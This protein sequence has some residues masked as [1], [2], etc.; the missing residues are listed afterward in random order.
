MTRVTGIYAA[1]D[2]PGPLDKADS[3]TLKLLFDSVFPEYFRKAGAPE[4]ARLAPSWAMM[5]QNPELALRL[6]RLSDYIISDMPWSKRADLRQLMTQAVN[7]H[8]MCEYAHQVHFDVS[9]N[10]G[11]S[12]ELQAAL[13]FWRTSGLFNDEQ[14]TVI[15]F[16]HAA[17][18]GTVSDELF[19][20]VV[21]LFGEKGTI[22]FTVATAYMSFWAI[23]LNTLRPEL[24]LT[25]PKSGD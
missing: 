5:T 25:S 22:E 21:S 3:Q 23:I 20:K 11:I 24:H 18:D 10:A 7:L 2:H 6:V 14:R 8:F 17:I 16:T 19:A 9:R 12:A 4:N 1:A 13:P 15:E